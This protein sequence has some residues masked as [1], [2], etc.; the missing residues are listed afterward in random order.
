MAMKELRCGE[1]IPQDGCNAKL[2][3]E[4]EWPGDPAVAIR[5]LDCGTVLCPRCARDHFKSDEK[6]RRIA[7]LMSEIDDLR[8]R[9]SQA[10]PAITEGVATP[11]LGRE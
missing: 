7:E 9:L 11:M 8:S 10:P 3:W 5:C 1:G 6:D 2:H 4:L